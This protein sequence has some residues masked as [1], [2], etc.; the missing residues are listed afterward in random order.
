MERPEFGTE[1]VNFKIFVREL[2]GL[3]C[4]GAAFRYLLAEQLYDLGYMPSIYSLDVWIRPA[5][6]P[7]GFIYYDYVLCYVYDVLC[8]SD[9]PFY[10]MKGIQG[11]FKLKR[12]RIEEPDIYLGAELSNMTKVDGQE[13]WD[14]SSDNYFTAGVTN[15]EPVLENC[16]LG[17]L[18]KCVT[19]LSCVYHP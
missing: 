6:K 11:K 15:M 4:F 8:I 18:P 2:C 7:G 10:T 19:T 17:L 13:C 16:G 14:M 1:Q 9:D 3:K 12:G 5:V